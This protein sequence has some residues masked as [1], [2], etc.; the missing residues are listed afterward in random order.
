M[1]KKSVCEIQESQAVEA[2]IDTLRQ[3]AAIEED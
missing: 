2:Y 1:R 3:K